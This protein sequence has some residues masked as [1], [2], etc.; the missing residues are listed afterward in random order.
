MILAEFL[1]APT[2]PSEPRPQNLQLTVSPDSVMRG[3]STFRLRWVTSS[4]TPM[5]NIC[6]GSSEAMLSNTALIWAG[7]TSL[8]AKP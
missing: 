1:L 3:S 7:V 8:E 6:R 5:V 4:T 2:V